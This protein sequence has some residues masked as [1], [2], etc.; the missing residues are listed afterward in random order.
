MDNL[1]S[2]FGWSIEAGDIGRALELAS[3]LQPLWLSRGRSRKDWRG[4]R[5]CSPKARQAST[6]W[7]RRS[8]PR[9]RRQGRALCLGQHLQLEYAEEALA[10][11]AN[12]TIRRCCSEHSPLAAAPPSTTPRWLNASSQKRS[13]WLATSATTGGCPRS[14]GSRRRSPSSRAT[15]SRCVQP[16]K[17]DA[18]LPMP[19]VTA[20]IRGNAGGGSPAHTCSRVISPS[21]RQ[22]RAVVADA[23]ADH[24]VMSQVTALMMLPHAL[25]FHGEASAARVAAESAIEAATELGGVSVGAIYIS[26]MTSH[27]AAGDIALASDAADAGWSHVS[28][29]Y[30]TAQINSA[31]VAQLALARGDLAGARRGVD[32]AIAATAGWILAAALTTRARIA[33]AR[34]SRNRLSATP[35]RPLHLAPASR[36]TSGIQT[37]SRFSRFSRRRRQPPRSGPALRRSGRHRQRTGEVRCRSTKPDTRRRWSRFE[38]RWAT[39]TSKRVGTK[40]PHCRRPRRSPS[41][42]AAVAN[43]SGRRAVGPR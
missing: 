2:A 41:R 27:L 6:S 35:M 15:P 14:S 30:G 29:L 37:S 42:S 43:A 17:K 19:S 20:S 24:D 12:S 16:P 9:A 7:H 28:S 1:R 26:L 38:M 11:A 10:F 32:D 22:Y 36:R 5:R 34:V 21:D 13:P 31:L 40:A 33:I 39:R 4:S 8:R 23:A 18:T 25:A 3:S